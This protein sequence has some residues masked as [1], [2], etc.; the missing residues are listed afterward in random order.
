MPGQPI[1]RPKYL[2]LSR[3]HVLR[4]LELEVS[5]E[6]NLGPLMMVRATQAASEPLCQMPTPV[7]ICDRQP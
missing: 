2:L 5:Q 4:R 1:T 7:P 6:Q 3:M